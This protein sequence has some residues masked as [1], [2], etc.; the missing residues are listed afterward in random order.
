MTARSSHRFRTLLFL[1][2]GTLLAHSAGATGASVPDGETAQPLTAEAV[3]GRYLEA[4][5]GA[6]TWRRLESIEMTGTYAAFSEESDFVLLRRKGDL[7]RLEYQLGGLP[8]IRARDTEGPWMQ[9]LFLTEE[10]QRVTEDPYKRQLERESWFGLELLDWQTKGISLELLG[11]GEIDGFAT[12]DLAV[13]L[14]DGGVETWHL[15]PDTYL[16]FAVDSTVKDYTQGPQEM[17][18]RTFYDDFREVDG[19]VLPF[20]QETEFWARLET[21]RVASVKLNPKISDQRFSPPPTPPPAAADEP[22]SSEPAADDNGNDGE[23][24]GEDGSDHG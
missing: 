1:A 23:G 10:P 11:A 16:E 22:T 9:H 20:S 24:E 18:Q 7:F 5:G 3:V 6:E 21:M 15:D 17:T 12:L 4:R 8:A 14:P 13:T 2:A 19:L